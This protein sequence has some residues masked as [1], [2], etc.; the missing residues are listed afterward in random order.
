MCNLD[1]IWERVI[2]ERINPVI[3]A[4]IVNPN[5][6]TREVTFASPKNENNWYY[7]EIH[8]P[9]LLWKHIANLVI[10]NLIWSKFF[11]HH[12]LL[13]W[14]SLLFLF[15]H[16]LYVVQ[17]WFAKQLHPRSS[18]RLQIFSSKKDDSLNLQGTCYTLLGKGGWIMMM[19]VTTNLLFLWCMLFVG[20]FRSVL[21]VFVQKYGKQL[22]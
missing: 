7:G 20:T 13:A 15:T 21:R 11:S 19:I 3:F 4:F 9:A 16:N 22:S 5:F 17:P 1:I 14:L 6:S 18:S 8:S 12:L 10:E 2:S